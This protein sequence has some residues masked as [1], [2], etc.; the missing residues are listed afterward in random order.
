MF[1]QCPAIKGAI[2][3]SILSRL[4]SK[5]FN[6]F[7][8]ETLG[9]RQEQDPECPYYARR[10]IPPILDAQIDSL[11]MEKMKTL[12]SSVLSTLRRMIAGQGRRHW[13]EI[14]LT[15]SILLLNLESV[16]RN[17]RRQIQRYKEH[18]SRLSDHY[19]VR[20]VDRYRF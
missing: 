17:Q 9:I 5:S 12:K 7:G 15:M 6:I 10:P 1:P 20:G 11:L 16:Y 4:I 14:Y 19:L 18:V 13:F 8:Q 2:Q 3:L